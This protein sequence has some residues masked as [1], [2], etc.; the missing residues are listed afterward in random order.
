LS[1]ED[2]AAR[3]DAVGEV[4]GLGPMVAVEL[5]QSRQ[6]KEPAA[7]LAS[8]TTAAARELGL[9]LLSCGLYGNVI[10]ILVPLVISDEELEQGLE[11]LER[12][13]VNAGERA[14]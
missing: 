4:R 11:L 10:R 9:V 3:V 12:A 8:A 13:L 7:A 2:I 6:T 5:V 1:L 14:A